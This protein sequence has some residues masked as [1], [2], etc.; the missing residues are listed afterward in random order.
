MRDPLK[1][2]QPGDVIEMRP[3]W[4]RTVKERHPNGVL[5]D[6]ASDFGDF[7]NCEVTLAGWRDSLLYSSR[8]L[9]AHQ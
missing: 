8:V 1:D 7:H 9:H 5:F 2:P 3:G 6:A 4:T